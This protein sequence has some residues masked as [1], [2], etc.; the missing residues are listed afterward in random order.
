M[1]KEN[2]FTSPDLYSSKYVYVRTLRKQHSFSALFGIVS[3]IPN[4]TGTYWGP[5]VNKVDC[6]SERKLGSENL[7][8]KVERT[9]GVQTIWKSSKCKRQKIHKTGKQRSQQK[10]L[11]RVSSHATT[12]WKATLI[13]NISSVWEV[14]PLLLAKHASSNLRHQLVKGVMR[15]ERNLNYYQDLQKDE[16]SSISFCGGKIIEWRLKTSFFHLTKH[17]HI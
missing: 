15:K 1:I 17:Y 3:F 13:G 11:C 12:L 10:A 9:Q 2:T 8:G 16:R 7:L 6:I 5:T 4:S 14:S